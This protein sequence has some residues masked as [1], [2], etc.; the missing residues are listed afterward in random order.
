MRAM[1]SEPSRSELFSRPF[2]GVFST[3]HE[4]DHQFRLQIIG[5]RCGFTATQ[6]RG[7][8]LLI[9]RCCT[10]PVA[11]LSPDGAIDLGRIENRW[12]SSIN[13]ALVELHLT[14]DDPDGDYAPE[15]HLT[16]VCTNPWTGTYIS[17]DQLLRM[18]AIMV[19]HAIEHV[20]FGDHRVARFSISPETSLPHFQ[21][22]LRA[23]GFFR[24]GEMVC[25]RR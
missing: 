16:Q 15:E 2:N 11:A 1:D 20:T 19:E 5:P 8:A 9:D 17:V 25:S 3:S 21:N 7:I 4:S 18:A 13:S 23:L 24:R 12:Q 14:D 10:H 22:A 6:L